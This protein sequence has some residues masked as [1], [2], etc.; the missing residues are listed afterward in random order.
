MLPAA[1]IGVG[2]NKCA[3]DVCRVPPGIPVPFTNVALHAIAIPFSFTTYVCMA[4]ALNLLSTIP[5]TLGDAPGV[6]GPG[7]AR[8]GTFQVGNPFVWV[9]LIPAVNLTCPAKGNAQ[10][11]AGAHV[12]PNI[13][14]VLYCLAHG[15]A[16]GEE[17]PPLGAGDLD[18]LRAA[19]HDGPPPRGRMIDDAVMLLPIPVFRADLPTIVFREIEELQRRGGRALILD[20]RG[21]P[22]G[23][24]DAGLLL[25]EDFL[26]EGAV[27]A[28]IVDEDGDETAHACRREQRHDVELAVLVDGRTASTAEVFAG[29]LQAHGRATLVG[30]RTFGKGRVESLDPSCRRVTVAR[31]SLPGGVDIEG[32]GV[33]PDIE[34]TRASEGDGDDAELAAA[35]EL[36][37][38]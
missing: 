34:I 20:L 12:V 31:C 38:L 19:V 13:V 30:Q 35:L 2:E 16:G 8:L 29:A 27:V 4:P 15:T 23:L 3:P 9:D 36:F 33:V 21:C 7:P 1:H 10:N 24:L 18:A 22:G 28:T 11:S 14:N 32:S 17:D 37:R 5:V 26:P 25:A 6:L